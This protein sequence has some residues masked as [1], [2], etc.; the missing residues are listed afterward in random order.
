MN[1]AARWGYQVPRALTRTALIAGPEHDV[2]LVFEFEFVGGAGGKRFGRH[3]EEET[4]PAS[5]HGGCAQ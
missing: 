4:A 2:A 5:A 1:S 3:H